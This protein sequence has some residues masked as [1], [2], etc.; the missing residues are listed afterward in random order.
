MSSRTTLACVAALA[1]ALLTPAAA[2]AGVSTRADRATAATAATGVSR[3]AVPVPLRAGPAGAPTLVGSTTGDVGAAAATF[4]VTYTGFTPEAK[5]AFQRAVNLWASKLNSPVPIT[6]KASF[7]PLGEGVLGSAGPTNIWRDF[8]GAPRAGTWYVDAIA[9][10]R[11]GRQ[12]D[13]SPDIVARFSSNFTNWHFGTAAAPAGKYD[14]TSVV[15]HEL[16]H[17]I[18][19]LGAGNVA[20]GTG[21]VR[22]AGMPVSYDRYT[23]TGVDKKLLSFAD[24]SSALATALKSGNVWF[25]STRVRNANG[26]KRAKLYAPGTWQPGSSYSH[27]D[28]TTYPPGT[29]HSLMTPRLGAAETI[30]EPGA[31]SRAI[32][33]DLGW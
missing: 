13:P 1:A 25:D 15:M 26:S 12:L 33:L 21:T 29:A 32:L 27:L 14:F 2:E 31:I 23:E 7:E 20:N 6:V 8:A 30:R 22:V 28:E 4:Q 9:N 19:F 5:A 18:G 24:N 17:G 11:A 16:G 10:K 3:P